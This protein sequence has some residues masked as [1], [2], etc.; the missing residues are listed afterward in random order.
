[1][2]PLNSKGDFSMAL[3]A[4]QLQVF[5]TDIEN[6]TNQ[7]IIDALASGNNNAIRDWYNSEASPAFY[8]FVTS[9]TVDEVRHSLDWD[10]VLDSSTG[11]TELQRWGF[12]TLLHNGTYDPRDENN[13]NA[14]VKIFPAG[15]S[16]TRSAVLADATKL[17]S[18][19]QQLFSSAATGPA[20]GDGSSASNAAISAI[21][22]VTLLDVREARK[23]IS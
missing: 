15:M 22:L 9:V 1:V 7:T 23:L 6:N 21:D 14:L 11:L 13:R 2:K 3:T 5:A 8:I 17:A 10:E 20:G 12:E 16:N 4:A 18:Y 19:A